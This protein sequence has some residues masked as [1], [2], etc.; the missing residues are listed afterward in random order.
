[1]STTILESA[2]HLLPKLGDLRPTLGLILGS[3]LGSLA[4]ELESAVSVPYEEIPHF[5]VSTV[6]GHAGRLVIG[7][8][9]GKQVI[10]M[11]GRFHYY[12]GYSLDKVT[13]PVRVMHA[14]GVR[15]LIVTNA[16]GAVHTGLTPGRLMLISDHLNFAFDNPLKGPNDSKLGVRFPDMSQPYAPRLLDVARQAAASEGLDV[17]QGVYA[18]MSGP[19]YETP[20][21][22]RML[23]LLGADAVGMSTVPETLA[24]RH[25][26]IDVLGISCITNMAAGILPQP[27]SHHEVMET[28]E[29]VKASFLSYMKAIISRL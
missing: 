14:L 20:A 7:E 27:L 11:Q 9:Q 13:F 23:R 26:G 2:V 6:Q 24:A 22:I 8:L 4:G 16:A 21:E 15:N 1:M 28:A 25:I 12:E 29:L 10:A 3:G 17:A 5:P 19:S 18:M